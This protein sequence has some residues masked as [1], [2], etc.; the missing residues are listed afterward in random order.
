MNRPPEPDP[1]KPM[2]SAEF[3]NQ[4][5]TADITGGPPEPPQPPK[6]R[7][8]VAAMV[9]F[10]L[11]SI[12]AFVLLLIGLAFLFMEQA[13]LPFIL[14]VAAFALV[15]PPLQM[16]YVRRVPLLRWKYLNMFL[17]VVLMFGGMIALG[18]I[19]GERKA[20]E[21]DL[22]PVTVSE[23]KLCH[24]I[25]DGTCASN[26][27]LFTRDIGE[28]HLVGTP[29]N[30]AADT[31][32]TLEVEY[33]PQP[34][35]P[36]LVKDE[37]FADPVQ[38]DGTIQLQY[39]PETLPVGR[40]EVT[41]RSDTEGFEPV[42]TSFEVWPSPDWVEAIASQTKPEVDTEIKSLSLCIDSNPE[43]VAG[44]QTEAELG[45]RCGA[46]L[47]TFT[48]DVTALKVDA[49]LED[50]QDGVQLT[51]QWFYQNDD[52]SWEEINSNTVDLDFAL[53]GFI[54]TLQGDFPPGNYEVLAMLEAHNRPPTRYPFTITKAE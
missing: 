1:K 39:N 24:T 22:P 36:E 48:S 45:D 11:L 2:F 18:S 49:D 23:I 13:A 41:L 32:L 29:E 30:F 6:N 44:T 50:A 26:S 14:F 16:L 10:V 3:Y 21:P 19:A 33:F 12:P 4:Q 51:F 27:N 15:F 17:A 47:D 5:S 8:G 25:T 52:G 9:F 34:S 35:Q 43:G 7:I 40:Y 37:T 54:F 28:I 46:S 31:P 53:N 20:A 38:D 42:T